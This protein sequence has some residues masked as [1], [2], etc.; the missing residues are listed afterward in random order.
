MMD[1]PTG[2]LKPRARAHA[3]DKITMEIM[4]LDVAPETGEDLVRQALEKYGRV[5]RCGRLR[6]SGGRF[7]NV[8]LNKVSNK[9]GSSA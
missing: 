2:P 4:V 3:V 8:M 1:F 9:L 7:K 6:L 5:K